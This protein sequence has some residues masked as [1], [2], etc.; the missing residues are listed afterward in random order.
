MPIDA[1]ELARRLK[2]LD[3]SLKGFP[4]DPTAQ[5]VHD[6][7]ARARRVESILDALGLDS[8]RNERKLLTELKKVRTRAGKVRDMDALTS[9]VIGL[10]A[11][12]DPDCIV[13]LVHYL[14][15]QRQRQAQKLHSLVKRYSQEL[16]SR[17]QASQRKVETDI[18]RFVKAKARLRDQRKGL[19]EGSPLHAATV[20]LRLVDEL[21]EVRRLGPD[22]LHSFR[23]EVKRLRYVL[24][25]AGEEH[26]QQ[27]QFINQLKSVQDAIGEWHDW[28]ELTGLA[29]E[30]LRH[31]RNCRIMPKLESTAQN[32]FRVALRIAGQMRHLYL[33]PAAVS[34]KSRR[35]SKTPPGR[36][37]APVLQA[38]SDILA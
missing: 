32:K 5:E 38:A 20:A 36:L 31:D 25:M 26:G 7:R 34:K 14:G 27:K 28:L 21:R 6:L 12:E 2:K 3:K 30:V 11:V 23:I 1:R 24:E 9:H 17:L 4:K 15:Y 18:N 35:G 37:P 29:H 22:N 33:A 8:A 13:R 16:R 10:N 19:Q